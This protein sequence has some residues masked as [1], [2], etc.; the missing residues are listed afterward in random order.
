MSISCG[1]ES[2]SRVVS[3]QGRMA[4]QSGKPRSRSP[5]RKSKAGARSQP[6]VPASEDQ[7]AVMTKGAAPPAAAFGLQVPETPLDVERAE[8]MAVALADL[9]RGSDDADDDDLLPAEERIRT[10]RDLLALGAGEVEL[11]M[12]RVGA[13]L[14]A[15]EL[16]AAE[17]AV[18]L[19]AVHAVPDMPEAM[20]GVIDLRGRLV[21]VYSPA[22]TLRM[23]HA[24]EGGVLVL[25]RSGERRVALVVDDVEDVIVL[26][27]TMLR[28]PPSADAD[29]L[30]LGVAFIGDALVT[31]VDAH[32][33]VAACAVPVSA[34]A[35]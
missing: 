29:N 27:R 15:F 20:R 33:L 14:F 8:A 26:D 24:P 10:M 35:A 32:V 11:L 23:P 12:F 5:K 31:V 18:E 9:P 3:P 13:E 22:G 6:A 19:E 21:P 2:A 7:S 1:Q 16:V 28:P 17:E 34:E 25:M 4:S 30:V